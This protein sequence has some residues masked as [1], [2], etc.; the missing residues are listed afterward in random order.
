MESASSQSASLPAALPFQR[1]GSAAAARK[2]LEE[3]RGLIAERFPESQRRAEDVLVT[4]FAALDQAGEGGAP[5]AAVSEVVASAPSCGGQLLVRSLL[6]TAR[7]THQYLALIDG[8]DGFDPQSEEEELLPHLLWVR[9]RKA[10]QALQATDLLVRDGN[11]GL[12]LLDL[13]GNQ[14]TELRRQPLSVWFRLQRVIEQS[15]GVL[16]V[17]SSQPLVSSAAVRVVLERQNLCEF[18]FGASPKG[19]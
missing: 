1:H 6:K 14:P 5:R 9:C 7:R 19:V 13:R 2:K 8:S 10:T 15:G 3:L 4:G 11:I 17:L 12:I 18:K 16:V